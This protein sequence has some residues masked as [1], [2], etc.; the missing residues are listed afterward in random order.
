MCV[1]AALVLNEFYSPPMGRAHTHRETHTQCD[2]TNVFMAQTGKTHYACALD[3]V[4]GILKY[5]FSFRVFGFTMSRNTCSWHY[6]SKIKSTQGTQTHKHTGG[7]AGRQTSGGEGVR[8]LDYAARNCGRSHEQIQ[9]HR[10]CLIYEQ[11]ESR[12]LLSLSLSVSVF[13]LLM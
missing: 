13:L 3:L 8:E 6:V 5:T 10:S 1:R 7:Q 12:A 4:L 9:H 11:R 2:Y